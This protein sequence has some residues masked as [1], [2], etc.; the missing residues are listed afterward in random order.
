MNQL[1]GQE[2]EVIRAGDDSS[3]DGAAIHTGRVIVRVAGR[4]VSVAAAN[5]VD[6]WSLPTT[7][8]PPRIH[9]ASTSSSPSVSAS[10][11]P[12]TSS[13]PAKVPPLGQALSAR[14]DVVAKRLEQEAAEMER[15][16]VQAVP[17][18]GRTPPSSATD[19]PLC[20]RSSSRFSSTAAGRSLWQSSPGRAGAVIVPPA[21]QGRPQDGEQEWSDPEPPSASGSDDAGSSHPAGEGP[22]VDPAVDAA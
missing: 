7:C 13:C 12:T 21:T 3:D 5:L 11:K 10:H 4:D 22:P 16:I 1:C 20:R 17:A 6:T 2:G 19:P 9:T 18:A 8:R 14:L 15:M